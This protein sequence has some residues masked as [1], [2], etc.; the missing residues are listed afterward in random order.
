MMTEWTVEA[1]KIILQYHFA[2]NLA[3]TYYNH[4]TTV[5]YIEALGVWMA[6]SGLCQYGDQLCMKIGNTRKLTRYRS[7][8]TNYYLIS[9][10]IFVA[11]SI[12][13]SC[14]AEVRFVLVLL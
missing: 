9:T 1:S 5:K 7:C 12:S 8:F 2:Q 3:S 10:Q 14:T 13:K 6:T 4:R 11:L